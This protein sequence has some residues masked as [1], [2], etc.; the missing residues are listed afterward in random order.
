[1]PPIDIWDPTTGTLRTVNVQTYQPADAAGHAAAADG[2]SWRSF[3]G[4]PIRTTK[5]FDHHWL[6]HRP[7]D[8]GEFRKAPEF[9]RWLDDLWRGARVDP[10]PRHIFSMDILS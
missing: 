1:M 10:R 8:L 5:R 7:I 3:D 6:T 4:G 9:K 2:T